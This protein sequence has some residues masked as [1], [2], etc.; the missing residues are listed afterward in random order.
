MPE[1]WQRAQKYGNKPYY[2]GLAELVRAK[3]SRRT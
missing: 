2:K 3:T 1:S